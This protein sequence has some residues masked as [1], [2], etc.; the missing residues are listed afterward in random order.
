MY[1]HLAKER[2]GMCVQGTKFGAWYPHDHDS[3]KNIVI[4]TFA[5]TKGIWTNN[6]N[7]RFWLKGFF[8]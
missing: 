6:A 8:C 5:I 3:T 1:A 2:V 4:R 7:V